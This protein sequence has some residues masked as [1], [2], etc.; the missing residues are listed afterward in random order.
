M[1]SYKHA[2]NTLCHVL[3]IPAPQAEVKVLPSRRWRF[4]FAWSEYK[5][6]LEIEGGVW[7][8]GRHTR[9]KGFIDDLEKYNAAALAGWTVYRIVPDWIEGGELA[10]LLEKMFDDH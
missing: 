9:A 1:K 2:I 6:A 10:L 3:G 8:G 5:I 4:D 7:V